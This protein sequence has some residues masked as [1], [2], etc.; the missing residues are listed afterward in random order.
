MADSSGNPRSVADVVGLCGTLAFA[1]GDYDQ[2]AARLKEAS[3]GTGYW[4][5]SHH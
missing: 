1:Q 4:A 5:M 3:T 2:A